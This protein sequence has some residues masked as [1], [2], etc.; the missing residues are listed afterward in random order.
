MQAHTTHTT[1]SNLKSPSSIGYS[2]VFTAESEWPQQATIVE[3]GWA[4]GRK[5]VTGMELQP[6][7]AEGEV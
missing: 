7:G 5:G 6:L 3:M 1:R 2:P 4:E